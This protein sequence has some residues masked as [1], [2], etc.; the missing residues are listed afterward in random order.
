[1]EGIVESKHV[2]WV[3]DA[4]QEHPTDYNARLSLVSSPDFFFSY[5]FP[6]FHPLRCPSPLPSQMTGATYFFFACL[7]LCLSRGHAAQ[8]TVGSRATRQVRVGAHFLR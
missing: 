5:L 3:E 8:S 6:P 4:V 7:V 2:E 1:M